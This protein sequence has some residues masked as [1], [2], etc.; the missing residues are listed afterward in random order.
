MVLPV[1][2]INKWFYYSHFFTI[3]IQETYDTPCY[4][5]V[6]VKNWGR[7]PPNGIFSLSE[8]YVPINKKD[9]HWLFAC[10]HFDIKS[11]EMWHSLGK[12]K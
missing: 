5:Y 8:L 3:I 11:I 10:V 2:K 6:H 9:T 1:D 7:R 12:D 4:N